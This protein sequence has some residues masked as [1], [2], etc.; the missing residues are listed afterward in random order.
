M[1]TSTAPH[2]RSLARQDWKGVRAVLLTLATILVALSPIIG[3]I[4]CALFFETGMGQG[5]M[6]PYLVSMLAMFVASPA[7]GRYIERRTRKVMAESDPE[8]FPTSAVVAGYFLG[9]GLTFAFFV[10]V[11]GDFLARWDMVGM[12]AFISIGTAY[13]GSLETRA[14]RARFRALFARYEERQARLQ[15]KLNIALQARD[16]SYGVWRKRKTRHIERVLDW[17]YL[18][19]ARA[20]QLRSNLESVIKKEKAL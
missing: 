2:Y 8:D 4:L 11:L 19:P 3:S 6:A 12:L 1:R 20:R 5:E 17:L 15:Q 9:G 16:G 14:Q 18:D 13:I 7:L 10:P